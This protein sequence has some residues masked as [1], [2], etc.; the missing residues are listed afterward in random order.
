MKKAEDDGI[1]L[2]K[3]VEKWL[4]SVGLTEKLPDLGFG[5]DDIPQLVD[6]A[7]NT[8][9]LDILL[10]LAPVEATRERVEQIYRDSIKPIE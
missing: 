10:N 8:P 4:N 6:L 7:F 3:Q 5:E 9:S 1:Y 2:A